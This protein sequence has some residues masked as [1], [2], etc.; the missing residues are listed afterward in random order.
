VIRRSGFKPVR[1][2]CRRFRAEL[3]EKTSRGLGEK[4]GFGDVTGRPGIKAQR[5]A[6]RR[7][8]IT[9]RRGDDGDQRP[10]RRPQ[11]WRGGFTDDPQ[12]ARPDLCLYDRQRMPLQVINGALL[13]HPIIEV[14]GEF[15][16]NACTI[17]QS[18]VLSDVDSSA[19]IP[20]RRRTRP[21]QSGTRPIAESHTVERDRRLRS[22]F[23]CRDSERIARAIRCWLAEL[24]RHTH[25]K[26]CRPNSRPLHLYNVPTRSDGPPVAGDVVKSIRS[27]ASCAIRA[28]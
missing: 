2:Y 19:A 25:R 24:T 16:R 17:R 6:D 12:V 20:R 1:R 9:E 4:T 27:N 11:I 7:R 21:A 15:S 10:L 23:R 18:E 14:A 26:R 28:A 5:G 22:R 3:A 13:T 8:Q